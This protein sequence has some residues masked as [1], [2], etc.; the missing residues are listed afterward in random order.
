MNIFFVNTTIAGSKHID[1]KVPYDAKWVKLRF[2][3]ST[4]TSNTPKSIV[5][6]RSQNGENWQVDS[7]AIPAGVTN[8]NNFVQ[9]ITN[10]VNASNK[11]EN[12][13]TITLKES[14]TSY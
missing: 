4:E 3:N 11:A 12:L 8:A 9:T 2:H 6:V 10:T 5:L 7:T 13:V 14:K 1:V